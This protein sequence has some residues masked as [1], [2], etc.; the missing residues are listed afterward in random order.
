MCK[1][2]VGVYDLGSRSEGWGK[3]Y[4]ERESIKDDFHIGCCVGNRGLHSKAGPKK[5]YEMCLRTICPRKTFTYC[6]P[7]PVD[8]SFVQGAL[9][10][11]HSQ[12]ANAWAVTFSPTSPPQQEHLRRKRKAGGW[13]WGKC[14]QVYLWEVDLVPWQWLEWR[15]NRIRRY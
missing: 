9:T 5:P 6:L 11:P 8:Q 14:W 12:V 3:P 1:Y 4:R 13:I 15:K 10:L 7:S 2:C